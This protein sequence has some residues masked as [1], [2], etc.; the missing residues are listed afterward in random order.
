MD[1]S[2][3]RPA[4][5]DTLFAIASSTKPFTSMLVLDLVQRGELSLNTKLSRFYPKLPS[6]AKIT[7]RMLLSHTSG[8]NEYF[9]DPQIS[10]TIANAPGHHWTRKEVLRGITK[11]LFKPGTQYSYSN[12]AYV[13]LGGL[14]EKV[15]KNTIEHAF[16]KRIANRR[17]LLS[18][19]FAYSP[20]RSY[21]FA[22]PYLRKNGGLQDAFA[23]GIGVPADYWGPVWTDGGLASTSADLARFGDALF[24]AKILPSNALKKMTR[25]NRFGSRLGIDEQSYEGRR[26]LGHNGRYGGYESE[27]WYD[28]TRGVTVAVNTNSEIS[29]LVTWEAVVAAYDHAAPSARPCAAVKRR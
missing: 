10:Q 28:R 8:L 20:K 26:W 1:L 19:T 29:S 9:D 24:R 18:S 2:S 21:R 5:P 25:A 23:P 17:H 3:N 14:I 6:A 15:T 13:V 12:S 4:K 11:V 16:R 27:L 7:V 22:H